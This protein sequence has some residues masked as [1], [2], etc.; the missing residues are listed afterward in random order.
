MRLLLS[1]ALVL[2]LAPAVAPS[3]ALAQV[4]P[5]PPDPKPDPS[6]GEERPDLFS[7]FYL[8]GA[9]GVANP[10]GSFYSNRWKPGPAF[11]A[12]LGWKPVPF[13]A[14]EG[15]FQGSVND[16][17]VPGVS[18]A[19]ITEL[20]AGARVFPLGNT[21]VQP[22]FAFSWSPMA[23]ADAG[24]V[25]LEGYTTT[26]AGGVR[27]EAQQ[28]FWLFADFR[29]SYIRWVSFSDETLGASARFA[30]QEHGD[31]VTVLVGGGARF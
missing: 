3:I 4:G 30:R 14:L 27:L 1:V 8:G 18:N 23:A 29:H 10:R 19:Q 26:L 7:G 28:P 17:R 24:E 20:A 25:S 2:A 11:H 5:E 12:V 6:Y 13:V 21:W 16:V 31:V 22:T 9:F 15:S